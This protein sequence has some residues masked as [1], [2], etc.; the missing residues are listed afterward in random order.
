PNATA[1]SRRKEGRRYQLPPS[2]HKKKVKKY[3]VRG[4]IHNNGTGAMFCEIWLLIPSRSAHPQA[5]RH[6]HSV[7]LLQVGRGLDFNCLAY[8]VDLEEN[9]VTPHRIAKHAYA[10]AHP[11]AWPELERSGSIASG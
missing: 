11:I 7:R 3:R 10:T 9:A 4:M 1:S 5:A 6:A 2:K 8:E